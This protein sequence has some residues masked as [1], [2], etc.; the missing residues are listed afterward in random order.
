MFD[1]ATWLYTKLHGALIGSD[2]FG[3][4]YY[5]HKKAADE[6]GRSR[7]WVIYKGLKEATKVPAQWF[8]WLHYQV[9]S[10]PLTNNKKYSWEKNHVPNLTGTQ[11]A[12]LPKGHPLK[13]SPRE[14]ATGDYMP[15][16]HE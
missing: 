14:K 3:N 9:D 13:N 7:R 8:G 4:K 16:R 10:P 11:Y 6:F 15:W 2:E 12:Y 5:Q 1:F